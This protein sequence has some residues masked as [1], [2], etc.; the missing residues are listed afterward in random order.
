ML[1]VI[2][3]AKTLNFDPQALCKTTTKPALHTH[4]KQLIDWLRKLSPKQLGKLMGISD[5]LA[6]EVHKYVSDWKAK[7]DPVGAKQAVLAFRGDVYQGLDADSFRAR[8]FEFTQQHLR[9]L[10]GLYGALR[11]LDLIQPY[12]LVMGT[13]LAGEHGKDL[14]DF[15][16]DRIAKCLKKTLAEQGDNVLVNLASNEYFKAAKAKT[17]DCRVITPVFKD[18]SG[19]DYKVLSFFAKKARGLMA[20]HIIREH[21]TEDGELLKFRAAGYKY[22]R[23][24]SSEDRPVFTRKQP[25]T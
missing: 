11:P 18:Y 17:F 7:Y 24:L 23:G 21:V 12:R 9:I 2:S 3:P 4:A 25:K 14:Y 22:N 19:G 10:S 16:G 15:W 20:R 13:R 8:D 6:T 1:V 5:K